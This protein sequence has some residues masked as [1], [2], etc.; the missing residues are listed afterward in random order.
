METLKKLV[1][2]GSKFQQGN[3]G[4][5]Y[6]N[7]RRNS[8]YRYWSALADLADNCIDANAD[9][10]TIKLFHE[11]NA[12]KGL[13]EIHIID[14]GHGMDYTTL[15]GSFSLGYTRQRS[16]N[17][18]GKFGVGGTEGSWSIA[19]KKVTLTREPCS[20]KIL[21]REYDLSVCQKE[22]SWGS[23]SRAATRDEKKMFY[24]ELGNSSGTYIILKQL[25]LITCKD[26]PKVKNTIVKR[27]A[28]YFCEH[29][30]SGI[31][32]SVDG[33]K[34][35]P[36]DPL[37]WN[38][39]GTI[40]EYGPLPVPGYPGI[41]LKIADVLNT[42]GHKASYQKQGGYVFRC[43]RL[44]VGSLVNGDKITGFWN[45]DPHWRGV[46]WQLN[47]DASHDV[48]L[49]TTTRK[50]DIAPKQELMDKIREIVMPIARECHRRE[51]EQGIIKTKD[52]TEQLVKNI[53]S[54]AN[55]PL[56]TRTI[57]SKGALNKKSEQS[58]QQGDDNNV[59]PLATQK[60]AKEKFNGI[61]IVLQDL[62]SM[63]PPGRTRVSEDR[64][65]YIVEINE[66]HPNI[67]KHYVNCE[68]P[69]TQT[70]VLSFLVSYLTTELEFPDTD[71]DIYDFKNSFNNKLSVF[72]RKL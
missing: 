23:T 40:Q 19:S 12:K 53:K 65:G 57:S 37:L 48:D 33:K 67:V 64:N 15:E 56:I 7:V 20:N 18:L 13:S 35:D 5:S 30:I 54:V 2:T 16:N 39:K 49:G 41:T 69:E 70:A 72:S 1:G 45:V 34:V 28:E 24:E 62:T 31:N 66:S 60:T 6:I 61:D 71:S 36:V 11:G 58:E 52:Q 46:R 10:I 21:C 4:W 63:G 68:H 22:D 27:F 25:D 44:I 3:I 51:K 42:E 32:F 59:I 50:D 47:Y 14:D 55:D 38:Q 43:N 9:N 29:I 17:Q 8:G 26:R